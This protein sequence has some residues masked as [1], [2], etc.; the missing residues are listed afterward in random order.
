MLELPLNDGMREA[1]NEEK[2]GEVAFGAK[3]EKKGHRSPEEVRVIFG[4]TQEFV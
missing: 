4:E 3:G 1:V 2:V